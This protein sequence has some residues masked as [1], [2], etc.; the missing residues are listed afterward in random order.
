MLETIMEKCLGKLEGQGHTFRFSLKHLCLVFPFEF[1]SEPALPPFGFSPSLHSVFSA[2]LPASE[3]GR[4]EETG[5]QR[6]DKNVG[7]E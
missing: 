7:W 2:D 6:E 5:L 3:E 4:L 1:P